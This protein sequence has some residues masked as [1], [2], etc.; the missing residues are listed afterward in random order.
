MNVGHNL[1]GGHLAMVT[2]TTAWLL[3]LWR[4]FHKA[5]SSAPLLHVK[6]GDLDMVLMDFDV[7]IV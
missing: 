1:I 4:G 5:P 7:C 2:L 6:Y 3:A